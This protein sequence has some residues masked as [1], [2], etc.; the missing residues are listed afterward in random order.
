MITLDFVTGEEP[1]EEEAVLEC[2]SCGYGI[3]YG[4]DYYNVEGKIYCVECMED[5]KNTL[6]G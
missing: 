3:F 5:F 4:D 1:E 6:E 2:D